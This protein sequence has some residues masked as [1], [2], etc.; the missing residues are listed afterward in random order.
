MGKEDLATEF[1]YSHEASSAPVTNQSAEHHTTTTNT[2]SQPNSSSAF[3]P[4]ET[5]KIGVDASMGFN[6]TENY[7]QTTLSSEPTFVEAMRKDGTNTTVVSDQ[8]L[9]SAAV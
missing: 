3:M 6:D 9:Q 1:R 7:N 8:K 2:T 5:S 4:S